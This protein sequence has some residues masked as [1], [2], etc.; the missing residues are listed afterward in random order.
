MV[1]RSTPCVWLTNHLDCVQTDPSSSYGAKVCEYLLQRTLAILG[2]LCSVNSAAAELAEEA[3]AERRR[4]DSPDADENVDGLSSPVRP[5]AGP[6]FSSVRPGRRRF[7]HQVFQTM[8]TAVSAICG[9]ALERRERCGLLLR[10]VA[11][12]ALSERGSVRAQ[13]DGTAVAD[14]VRGSH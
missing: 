4:G 2:S 13:L 11:L 14:A 7:V 1:I 9:L 10:R 5:P 3:A 6:P 12:G 8:A